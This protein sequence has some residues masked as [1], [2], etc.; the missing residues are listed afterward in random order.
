MNDEIRILWILKLNLWRPRLTRGRATLSR[1]CIN[2]S[3]SSIEKTH[4]EKFSFELIFHQI[5]ILYT[6][7]NGKYRTDTTLN[8][9]YIFFFSR[10]LTFGRATLS[11]RC[12]R[13]STSRPRWVTRSSPSW[14]RR[15][16]SYILLIQRINELIRAV[17]FRLF[18]KNV[19]LPQKT[20]C[21]RLTE[22]ANKILN[23]WD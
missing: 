15:T 20:V 10:Q 19:N 22:N 5:P 21:S 7:F 23:I 9:I 2:S 16:R 13:C 3:Y 6:G 14:E 12:S 11:R 4:E 8:L 17:L 18:P 1:R